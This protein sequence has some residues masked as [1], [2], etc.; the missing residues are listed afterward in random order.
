MTD[1]FYSNVSDIIDSNVPLKLL[2]RKETRFC[3]KPWITPGLKA[4]IY[5]KNRLYKNF[6]R[7]RSYYSH[8]KFKTYRNKLNHLIKTSKSNYYKEYFVTNKTNTKEIWKGIRQIITLKSKSS[9]TPNKLVKDGHEIKNVKEIANEFNNYFSNI[10]KNLASAIPTTNLSFE[11]YLDSPQASSFYLFP[12]SAMEIEN[13]ISTLKPSKA[14]GPF[15]IPTSL[16]KTLKMVISYPLEILF[17]HSFATGTVPKQFKL[18]KVIPIHK[19]GSVFAVSNYRPIS[20]L[21][22]FNKIIEKLMYNRLINYLG[23]LSIISDNQF[24]FRSKHSTIHALLLPTDKIQKAIDK[25][26]YSCGIFLDLCKAFDTVNH[27]ILLTK[28]EYY[29]IRGVAH[30]WFTS[31][32]SDRKQFVSL[33]GTNSEYQTLTCGVPQG[34]VLGPLLFLLYVNDICNC[35]SILEFHLFADDTNVFLSDTN[36]QK[37]ELNLNIELGKVSHWLNANKLSL[38]IEKTSFVI[39]HPPQRKISYQ[40]N[41]RISNNLIKQD[42]KLKYLGL[43]IDSNLNWKSHLHELGKKVARNIGILSK[44]RH[45]VNNSILY[46]LYYSLIYPLLTYG[47]LV[48]DNTYHTTLKPIITLQKRALRIITYS[49]PHEHSDPLFKQLDLLKL[50]DLVVFHNALFMYQYHKNLLPKS[51][52]NFFEAVSSK[53]QYNTRFA[54]RLTYYINPDRTNFGKFNIRFAAA[55]VWNDLDNNL[56]QLPP[57]SFKTKI[58]QNLIQSYI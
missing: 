6:L 36:I 25:G 3:S 5:N 13:I 20:L 45:F 57:K 15:S 35:S 43:I 30:A 22:N 4:S 8:C 52:N 37:L 17:N 49:K 54:S 40:M 32:L 44:I 1:I 11:H 50:V 31:Y 24:G 33:H 28:L 21:S 34:S 46:Q 9:F 29:G 18:A 39:S 51:F 42:R 2:S 10:G 12:T 41:L 26:T 56:K 58:K 47:L 48:W 16:L 38:N 27:N 55:A 19:N 7:K 53:H 14:T 23:K